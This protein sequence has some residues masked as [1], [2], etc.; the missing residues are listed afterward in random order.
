MNI[1]EIKNKEFD[2]GMRGYRQE[3]VHSYL[4]EICGYI[5]ELQNEKT[6]LLKKMEVLALKVEEYRKDEESI[7]EALLGAQK[8]GKTVLSEAQEKAAALSKESEEKSKKLTES[9][10]KE[11]EKMLTEAKSV[12]QTMLNKA[13]TE[14]EK[15]VTEAKRNVENIVRNTKYEIDKEQNNLTRMQKEVSVFK[16]QLLDLYRNHIDLIKKLPE[17]EMAEKDLK[18]EKEVRELNKKLYEQKSIDQA[19][20]VVVNTQTI[21]NQPKPAQPPTA[22]VSSTPPETPE[23]KV[24]EEKKPETNAAPAAPKEA[25]SA[26]PAPEEKKENASSEIATAKIQETKEYDKEEIKSVVN[27]HFK[28]A[29][30]RPME[31]QADPQPTPEE[32]K[33]ATEPL[34]T[35]REHYVKKFGEL[36][37]GGKSKQS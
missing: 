9:A 34:E 2:T 5:K 14:S 10:K 33:F 24:Q 32:K 22:T 30:V 19:K 4:N 20:D 6:D 8:L 17:S 1:D 13:K 36:Q 23:E 18:K 15:M 29:N 16:S 21:S 7:R 25:A 35:P 3:E 26:A 12:A 11:A 37:F 28:S 27:P 31:P